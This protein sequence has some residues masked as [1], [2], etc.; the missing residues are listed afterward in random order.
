MDK[1]LPKILN[2]N[3]CA[4][5]MVIGQVK[6]YCNIKIYAW[7]CFLLQQKQQNSKFIRE[8]KSK[9]KTHFSK[10]WTKFPAMNPKPPS[11]SYNSVFNP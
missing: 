1:K 6:C 2:K 9:K 5:L 10:C 8:Y 3:V 4:V 7:I 11:P